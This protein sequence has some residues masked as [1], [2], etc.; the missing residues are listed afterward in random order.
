[1]SKLSD[2][3]ARKVALKEKQENIAEQIAQIDEQL[4]EEGAGNHD[5]GEWTLQLQPNRTLN[6]SRFIDAFPVAQYPHL[7]KAVPDTA[8][9]KEHIA[10]VALGQYYDEGRLKVVVK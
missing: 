2:L 1:M 10:P 3:V 5:A 7:F 4:R 9:I 8:A 6:A